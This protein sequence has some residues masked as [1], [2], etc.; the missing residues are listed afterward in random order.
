MTDKTDV[1]CNLITAFMRVRDDVVQHSEIGDMVR[2]IVPDEAERFGFYIWHLYNRATI[3]RVGRGAY[4]LSTPEE[5]RLALD[6]SMQNPKPS[7]VDRVHSLYWCHLPEHSDAFTQGY[8][9]IAAD[10]KRRERDHRRSG[11]FPPDFVFTVLAENLTRFEAAKM[12]WE[13]R[14]QRRIGW[15][16]KKGG[17]KFIR[18]L[19][20]A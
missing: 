11:R 12:E 3:R 16:T 2:K 10:H 17:G 14:K 18:S 9:G 4:R 6:S 13:R 19:L 20:A 7:D 1:I 8:V 15:N 5:M